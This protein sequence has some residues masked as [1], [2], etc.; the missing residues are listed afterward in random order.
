MNYALKKLATKIA[1]LEH[2]IQTSE[3]KLEVAKAE[4]G[5]MTLAKSVPLGIQDMVVLDEMI[6]EIYQKKYKN[7]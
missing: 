6:Q 4:R 3:D 1:E 7:S 5:I 2:T